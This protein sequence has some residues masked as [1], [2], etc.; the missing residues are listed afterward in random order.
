MINNQTMVKQIIP[1]LL[2]SIV[3]IAN[4]CVE[5]IEPG[6]TVIGSSWTLNLDLSALCNDYWLNG[7][8]YGIM[9]NTTHT[10]LIRFDTY[11]KEGSTIPKLRITYSVPEIQDIVPAF[12]LSM[13]VIGVCIRFK[14]RGGSSGYR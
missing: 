6:P 2:L 11:E 4:E 7:E 13:F 12:F 9:I 10:E 1:F 14:R 8:N 5:I 3:F